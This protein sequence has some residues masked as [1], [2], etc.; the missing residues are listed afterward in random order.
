MNLAS[1]I[2]QV[3]GSSG[4][5]RARTDAA[6]TM[7]EIAISLAIIGFAL[8]AII[9]V[10]PRGLE[11]QKE[12]RQET[13][14]NQDAQYLLDAIRN[15]ARGLDDLTNY[16]FAIT[17]WWA[18]YDTNVAPGNPWLLVA[19]GRDG[20]SRL[21]SDIT[22]IIP[23]PFYPL[24]SGS[25]I[26]GLL[27]T[28]KYRAAGGVVYSNHVV[29]YVRALSGSAA[30]KF[31]QNDAAVQDLAFSYRL[32]SEVVPLAGADTNSPYGKNL[33]ANLREVR[34]LFRWP[35]LPDGNVPVNGGRQVYRSLVGGSMTNEPLGSPLWFFEPAVYAS[36]PKP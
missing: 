34:L 31:P 5:R 13:I 26:I 6:F 1:P 21:G 4:N 14:I 2:G 28:P 24:D 18:S 8:V 23:A 15:G 10:L 16:V 9:G 3:A 32:V 30:E 29:A 12:N 19:P 35:L 20:Y 7:V 33:Q 27:G 11:V 22:S 17:N 36:I 25:N